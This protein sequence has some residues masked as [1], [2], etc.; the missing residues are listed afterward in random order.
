[1]QAGRGFRLAPRRLLITAWP[2]L[3][4]ALLLLAVRFS[5][6]AALSDLYAVLSRPFW[7][8]SAQAE[9]LRSAQRL[10]QQSR[11]VQL[12]ADNKRLR[13]M[14]DLRE[15]GGAL[16]SAPVIARPASLWWQQLLLAQGAM[17]GLA[18][19]DV[20]LA[21]GGLVGR[22]AS[23]TPTTALVELLTDPTSKVGV[24]VP[25]TGEHGLLVGTGT[26]RPVL[27][28][29]DRDTRA[30]AGDLVTTSPASTLLPPNVTV[31]VLQQLDLQGTPAPEARVQLSAPIEA[32]DW[33]QVRSMAH[34]AKP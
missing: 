3:V 28:F 19:G 24:W 32:L 18:S 26:A 8:G 4:V 21:P 20:V 16:V 25:R 23:V 10:D 27:R 15:Q 13:Q 11:L 5:K 9:W 7:P 2:W 22:L 6:G 1:M 30:R 31:G 14:L 12:E 17:A 29:L 33:V 34:G